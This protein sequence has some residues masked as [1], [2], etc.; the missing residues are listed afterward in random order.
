MPNPE[1]KLT[2]KQQRFIQAYHLS[3][4]ATQ[5]AKDSGY[6]PD[7]ARE[8]ASENLTK[9]AV[10]EALKK[11]NDKQTKKFEIKRE[12]LLGRLLAIADKEEARDSDKINAIQTIA[13]MTGLNEPETLNVNN[14]I[15]RDT[16]KDFDDDE[17]IALVK[18]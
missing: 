5:A 8:I 18:K 17:L 10:Q 14:K 6:S 16:F 12:D 7:S 9:P 11:M 3:G 1:T 4:N 15:T 2:P 13:K